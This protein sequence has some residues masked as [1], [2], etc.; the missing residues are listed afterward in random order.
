MVSALGGVRVPSGYRNVQIAPLVD[1]FE[2]LQ[3]EKLPITV[4]WSPLVGDEQIGART[5]PMQRYVRDGTK[6]D[7]TR[8]AARSRHC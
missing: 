6:H 7:P 5:T 2:N 4:Y 8:T 1:P 3:R